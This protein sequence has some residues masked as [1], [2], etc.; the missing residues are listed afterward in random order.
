L[1]LP[2]EF[3]KKQDQAVRAGDI[4]LEKLIQMQEELNRLI[5]VHLEKIGNT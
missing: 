4:V 3:G 5:T 2:G 1:S